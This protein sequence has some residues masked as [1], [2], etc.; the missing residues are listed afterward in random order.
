MSRAVNEWG[1]TDKQERFAQA[2]IECGENATE[3][4][5]Q[6]YGVKT[7]KPETVN[8]KAHDVAHNGK[9]LARINGLRAEAAKRHHVT[10][11]SLVAELDETRRT[12]LAAETPQTSAAVAAT[13]GKAKLMGLDKQVLEHTGLVSVNVTSDDI[14]QFI[15]VFNRDC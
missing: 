15:Q 13:M 3:A 1:L 2:F 9:V 6:S 7:M 12:A 14:R 5:R 8:R 10:V 11:D 4:Y